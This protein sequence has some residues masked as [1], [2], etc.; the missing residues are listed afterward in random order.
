MNFGKRTP[1]INVPI[2]TAISAA[3]GRKLAT[4]RKVCPAFH[5]KRCGYIATKQCK[6]AASQC[7]EELNCAQR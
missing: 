6:Q 3:A 2:V 5:E 1:R 7:G 4:I